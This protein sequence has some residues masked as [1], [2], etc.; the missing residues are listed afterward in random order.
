M[1]PM[2]DD[3]LAIVL[4]LRLDFGLFAILSTSAVAALAVW[5][6][7]I[8]SYDRSFRL[9]WMVLVLVLLSGIIV[10]EWAGEQA[11][12]R[13]QARIAS[14]APTYALE[15][16]R[17]GHA[18]LTPETAPDDGEIA[19]LRRKFSRTVYEIIREEIK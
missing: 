8:K 3:L 13:M 7:R 4:S 19:V 17:A 16:Q 18:R 1:V 9:A 5:L 11:Q 15:L 12:E 2:I 6:H 10:V 14:F